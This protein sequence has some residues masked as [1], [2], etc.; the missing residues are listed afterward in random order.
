[1]KLRRVQTRRLL[2]YS[3]YM[4]TLSILQVTLPSSFAI[5]GA[6]PDLTLV[7]AILAGYLYGVG[8][9]ILVGLTAGFLR[10]MLAGRSVGLGML[11]LMYAAILAWY[12]FRGQFRRSLIMGLV[13]VLIMTTL[14]QAV[15]YLLSWLL[16]MLPD[17]VPSLARILRLF[18]LSLPEQLLANLL[19]A[20]PL[21]ILLRY[22][23]PYDRNANQDELE[24][25]ITGDGV[26][27]TN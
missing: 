7:L 23:G 26:W 10:D 25:P 16:P 5:M 6:R 24:D 15:I 21:M 17:Q 11:L 9:G 20:V 22:A 18:A 3:G 19:A 4:I 27:Q 2:V 13:Q 1:M 8:D 14:Y 12:L